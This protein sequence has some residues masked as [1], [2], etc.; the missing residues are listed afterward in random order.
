MCCAYTTYFPTGERQSG[1]GLRVGVG[2]RHRQKVEKH[3]IIVLQ[4]EV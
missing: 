4:A 1:G 2:P 3:Q